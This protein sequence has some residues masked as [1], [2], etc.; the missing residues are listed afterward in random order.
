MEETLAI[1]VESRRTLIKG[2]DELISQFW[3][4][5][6]FILTKYSF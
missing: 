2:E 3:D 6:A 1:A 4:S 5:N